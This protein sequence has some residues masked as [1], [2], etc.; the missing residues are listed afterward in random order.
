MIRKFVMLTLAMAATAYSVQASL[1]AQWMFNENTGTTATEVMNTPAT[2]AIL[3]V[4][5]LW[6]PNSYEGAAA[7][8]FNGSS[9]ADA[10]YNS[11]YDVG[12]SSF[13]VSFWMKHDVTGSDTYAEQD[14]FVHGTISGTAGSGCR[15][16]MFLKNGLLNVNT[17]DNAGKGALTI[18][19]EYVATG[20]WVH[21]AMTRDVTTGDLSLYTNGLFRGTVQSDYVKS[22]I[23]KNSEGLTFGSKPLLDTRGNYYTGGLDDFRIYDSV[24]TTAEIETLADHTAPTLVANWDFSDASGTTATELVNGFDGALSGG[25]TWGTGQFGG[26]ADFDGVDGQVDVPYNSALD[27]GTD[28]ITL[29]FWVKHDTTTSGATD[30]PIFVKGTVSGSTGTGCRYVVYLKNGSLCFETD[31]NT[32]KGS[33][34]IADSYITTGNWVHVVLMRDATTGDM[35]A[36]IDGVLVSIVV[37][38]DA[39]LDITSAGE[40]VTFGT[41]HANDASSAFFPGSLDEFRIYNGLMSLSE[42]EALMLVPVEMSGF[43]I[44]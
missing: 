4:G 9:Y 5:N 3:S 16:A 21:V 10:D 32:A 14:I 25:V 11:S 18:A 17:D 41:Y 26:S 23:L 37:D 19:D 38:S 22:D 34:T 24:L 43:V 40:G 15:Y 28:D 13:T 29:S 30:E 33:L 36:Y 27:L 1:V 42:I 2:D 44:E 8:E 39:T 12:T 20:E 31:D 35:R 7:L 6:T